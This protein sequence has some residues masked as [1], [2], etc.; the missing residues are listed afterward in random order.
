[1]VT[2]Q[3]CGQDD[4]L[5]LQE[6]F[7]SH[8]GITEVVN[9]LFQGKIMVEQPGLQPCYIPIHAHRPKNHPYQKVEMVVVSD[10][11]GKGLK[12]SDAREA[13]AEW[14][15]RWITRHVNSEVIEDSENRREM[16]KLNTVTLP[17]SCGRLPSSSRT[18]RR[19][20]G[21]ASPTSWKARS[22]ST[23][24]KRYSILSTSCA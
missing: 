6:N 18:L 14:I 12:A 22:I 24:R 8:S 9:Q 20:S 3:V 16:R 5:K 13:E 4:T 1:M 15:A 19:L 11:E 7:R 2:K 17:C 10:E 21:T 23:P